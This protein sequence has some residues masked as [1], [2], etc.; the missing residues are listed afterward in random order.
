M[1]LSTVFK[2]PLSPNE[3]EDKRWAYLCRVELPYSG[4]II[5]STPHVSDDEDTEP[6][7]RSKKKTCGYPPTRARK[8]RLERQQRARNRP[9]YKGKFIKNEMSDII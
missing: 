1:E 6:I 3:F 4:D 7:K 2:E 5:E 8:Q 9:R